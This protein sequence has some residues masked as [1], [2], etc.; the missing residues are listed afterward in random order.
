MPSLKNLV[1]CIFGR[2]EVLEYAGTSGQGAKWRCKCECGTERPVNAA[3]L[4]SGKSTSC[5][6][7]MREANSL[8]AKHGHMRGGKQSPTYSVWR[9]MLRRCSDPAHP[10]YRN[11]GGKGIKVC[12]RWMVFD[13]FLEDM[14]ARPDG[15]TLDRIDGN[16]GY[17]KENCRWFTMTEQ[18][19]NRANNHRLTYRGESHTVSQWAVILGIREGTIRSRL[20]RGASDEEALRP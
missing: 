7:L 15:K 10:S 1:G 20:F 9:S 2:W 11:Y 8:A 5:G 4:L 18:A 14:G 3:A 13:A 16:K 6:C 17:S 12:D 19:N